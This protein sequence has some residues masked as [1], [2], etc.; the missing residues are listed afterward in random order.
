MKKTILTLSVLA[1]GNVF[2]N[3]EDTSVWQ[4]LQINTKSQ[5]RNISTVEAIKKRTLILDETRLKNILLLSKDSNFV[6]RPANKTESIEIDVPLPDGG[7]ARVKVINSPILAPELAERY[8]DIKTW[9][10]KGVDDP[11]ISGRI[12][13]TRQGFHG[14]LTLADGDTVYIDPAKNSSAA[15]YNSLSKYNNASHFHTDFNCQVHNDHA[16]HTNQFSILSSAKRLANLPA[17]DLKTYRLAIAGTAEYTASFGGQNAA[18]DATTTTINR[19]NEIYQRDLGIRLQLVTGTGYMY[20][21]AASDPY[22][23]NDASE[24]IDENMANM[25]ANMGNAN[26]DLGHVFAQSPLGGMAFIGV[27]CLDSAN[28]KGHLVNGI[29]AGGATGIIDPQGETFSIDY[30][31]HEIG[32]QLGASHT[33]NSIEGSCGGGNRTE[34]VAV[35]PGSGSTI[36]SYGGLCGSDDLQSGSDAMF[37]FASISQ[38]NGYTRNGVGNNCGS[39]SSAGNQNPDANAGSNIKIP[40]NTPFLLDGIVTNGATYSWDQVDTGT[41]STV[42]LDTG[43]NAIIRSLLPSANEDRYLPRLSDLFAGSSTIGEI[44]PQ[45][46]R[47]LNFAFVVRDGNGGIGTA[48]KNV[49]VTNTQSTFTVV[50]QPLAE[51]L[52]IGENVT[53]IWDTAGT[54]NAPINCSN[55]DIQLLRSNGVKNMILA[56]TANDGIESVTIPETTP[57]MTGARIMV[58][59]SDN[60]FFNISAGSITIQEDG[61]T[62]VLSDYDNDGTP[63]VTDTDDDDDGVSDADELANNTNPKNSDSDRNGIL[64]GEED[65]DGD[66]KSDGEESDATKSAITDVDGDGIADL[67]QGLTGEHEDPNSP[68]AQNLSSSGGSMS[69]LLLPLLLLVGSRRRFFQ[70]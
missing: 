57:V 5:Q 46:T 48:F 68:L 3:S 70:R 42:S 40:A 53:I 9:A 62:P 51:T 54:N 28:V 6:L 25:N 14:M 30:V 27:A 15:I 32:H 56:S 33:F 18:F 50:S 2:A 52:P 11:A 35:E 20:T 24:L 13:F 64:D 43:N 21:N 12:D 69:F 66:G 59:C 19:V 8:P 17:L 60:S 36:M 39:N 16:V 10:V 34:V 65:T 61:N 63:D 47:E 55:V 49:E 37:H 41:A 45:T 1:C 26:Y 58:G 23:D 31:A 7:F 67:T 44:L 22:T 38:I 4:D 29:K